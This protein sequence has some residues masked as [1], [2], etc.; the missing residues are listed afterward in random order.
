MEK[1]AKTNPRR[2][3]LLNSDDEEKKSTVHEETQEILLS[4]CADIYWQ[5]VL[6]DNK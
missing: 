3:T 1:Q 2:L 4:G 5:A 6:T